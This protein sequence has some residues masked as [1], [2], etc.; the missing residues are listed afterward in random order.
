MAELAGNVLYYGDNLDVLR[1]FVERLT[2]REVEDPSG[3]V[4][5][6]R[7]CP[8]CKLTAA[9]EINAGVAAGRAEFGAFFDHPLACRRG[10][11]VGGADQSELVRALDSVRTARA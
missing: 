1:R 4:P 2:R 5:S 7:P 8:C 6:P 9:H 10:S 3:R 11:G